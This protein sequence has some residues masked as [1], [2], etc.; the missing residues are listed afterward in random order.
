MLKKLLLII[1]A[2]SLSLMLFACGTQCTEHKDA[3]GDFIC[4]V[5]KEKLEGP[6]D[7]E[8]VLIDEGTALFDIVLGDDVDANIRFTLTELKSQ[9]EDVGIDIEIKD[10]SSTEGECEVLVGTVLTRGDK[11]QLDRY[12]Y[13]LE[14][15]AI[16]IIE[17]K[18]VIV[19]GSDDSLKEALEIFIEDILE[20][21]DLD[22]L[23]TVTMKAEQQKEVIQDDYDITSVKIGETNLKGYVI[24][25]NLSDANY[26][27]QVNEL[28]S[29]VYKKTGIYLKTVNLTQ[30]YDKAIIVRHAS[31]DDSGEDSFRIYVDGKDNLII[32]CEYDNRF[33]ENFAS[34]VANTFT[35]GEGDVVIKNGKDGKVFVK[36]ISIVTYK[37][38]GAAG[39]GKTDDFEAI[40]AAHDFANISGQ[41]V[42][43]QKNKTYYIYETR[44][45]ATGKTPQTIDI[46]T[47]VDWNG[48]T[49]IIDDR[50]MNPH[51]GTYRTGKHIFRILPEEDMEAYSAK[52]DAVAKLNA[53]AEAGLLGPETTNV[54]IGLGAPAMLIIY[55]SS[56]KVYIRYGSNAN[57][58]DDQ[59]EVVLIDQEGNIKEGTELLLSYDKVTGI[60][61]VP[62]EVEEIRVENGKFRCIASDSS[63]YS[64]AGYVANGNKVCKSY[65]SR[66][67][68]IMRSNVIV[69]G[70]EHYVEGEY[71][72]DEKE[73]GF[74]N[75]PYRGFYTVS[76][77]NNV[78]IENCVMSGRRYYGT[79]TYGISMGEANDIL[80][81]NCTQHNF[82]KDG[83]VNTGTIVSTQDTEYWGVG[84]SSYCKNIEYNGCILS[85]FDAHCG[86][87]N[88]RLIDSKLSMINIIGGGLLY[89]ENCEII[90]T[91]LFYLREDYGGTW[92][93]E[94]YIKDSKLTTGG[95]PSRLVEIKWH[96]HD[97]GYT[98]YFPNIVIDNL[99][100]DGATSINLVE[101]GTSTT[102]DIHKENYG[103]ENLNPMVQPEYVKIINNKAGI[104]YY[105]PECDFFGGKS[106]SILDG[107]TVE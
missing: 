81:K 86:V 70:I 53:M 7:D 76:T 20:A 55:N 15:Y 39:D 2:L 82:Y 37:E 52:S 98:C 66:G 92:K 33:A 5:C 49:F 72:L 43:A 84:G 11:Y 69:S 75:H 46:R 62:T 25:T 91:R 95:K 89:I 21:E 38:F 57:N 93:G 24:A 45:N 77:A 102:T 63:V 87:Y 34:F 65:I 31:K 8:L 22:E 61:V 60:T 23:S 101:P 80:W 18:I 73:N 47:N 28:Q 71:S 58:G 59:H 29:I 100:T 79:G 97:F 40:K 90:S 3:D 12:E 54:D 83:D 85:R 67:M 26:R 27:N 44:K 16:K 106:G 41:K 68:Q 48:A 13:G 56:H 96:N 94:L 6:S 4:D 14:G 51:D 78:T 36:D 42:V 19:G 74:G 1:L 107:F 105:A 104:T 32:E 88:A 10:E 17:N 30:D 50:G 9:L 99:T 64:C 103:G 35:K